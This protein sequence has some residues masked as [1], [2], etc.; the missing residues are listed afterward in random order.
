MAKGTTSVE[1]LTR[2]QIDSVIEQISAGDLIEAMG[3]SANPPG[4]KV[5]AAVFNAVGERAGLANGVAASH[6]VRLADFQYL[7]QQIGEAVN[8]SSPKSEDGEV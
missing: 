3:D 1:W 2:E 6:R 5:A 7:A 4:H 8:I